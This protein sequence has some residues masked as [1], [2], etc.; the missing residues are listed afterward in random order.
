MTYPGHVQ[1][2]VVSA[3]RPGAWRG[4]ALASLSLAIGT[5]SAS[6][7]VSN[8]LGIRFR[9][10]TAG[11]PATVEIRLKPRREFDSVRIEAASGVAA[12][13]PPCTFADVVPGGS[14]A[15]RVE[16]AGVPSE[17]AM[18]LNVV[19]THASPGGGLPETEIHHLSVKNASFL[20]A[21]RVPA[22]S[23]HAVSNP[24]PTSK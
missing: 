14:Y 24:I 4:A 21:K 8:E 23:H 6:V 5:A 7:P 1:A 10:I 18:T 17:P 22:A 11:P 3:L 16:V 20:L 12:L 19:A 9:V 15:C 13:T 2:A